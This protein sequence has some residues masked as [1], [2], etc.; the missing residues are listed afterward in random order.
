MAWSRVVERDLSKERLAISLQLKRLAVC[1]PAHKAET[2]RRDQSIR[3]LVSDAENANAQG[4]RSC[5]AAIRLDVPVWEDA[6]K[7]AVN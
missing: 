7:F 6:E 4:P 2:V 5:N 1:A 3:Q